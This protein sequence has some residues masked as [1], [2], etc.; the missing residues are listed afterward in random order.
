MADDKRRAE[1]I[2]RALIVLGA[3]F[4]TWCGL[5]L[6]LL[7]GLAAFALGAGFFTGAAVA[8]AAGE[9]RRERRM[10]ERDG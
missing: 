8:I 5:W 9:D 2:D 6:F 1:L 3:F 7:Y 10:R 4:A